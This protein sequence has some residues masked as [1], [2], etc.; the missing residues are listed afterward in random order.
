MYIAMNHF[1]VAADRGDDFVRRWRERKSYLDEVAGFLAFHLVRGK[2][3][4]DGTRR[5]ASH[6][7]WRSRQAFL[8]WT[9][10]EAFRKAHGGTRNE[11]GV[12][13]G[14]PEFR[15]WEAVDLDAGGGSGDP[16]NL[17]ASGS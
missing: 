13:L 12:L 9:H 5:Y 17:S 6:T 14:H 10:S 1:R 3:E 11:P 15:G 8:D 16:G 7:T 2:D 4:E